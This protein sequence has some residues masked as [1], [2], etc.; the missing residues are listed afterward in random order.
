[1]ATRKERLEKFAKFDLANTLIEQANK[2]ALCDSN[3]MKTKNKGDLK[4]TYDNA[5][6]DLESAPLNLIS[7]RRNYFVYSFGQQYYDDFREKKIKATVDELGDKLTSN[8]VEF[9]KMINNNLNSYDVSSIYFKNM[10][11]I[12]ERYSSDIDKLK[13]KIRKQDNEYNLNARRVNYEDDEIT[14]MNFWVYAS[15][16]CYFVCLAIFIAMF[17]G[18]KLYRDKS[19]FVIFSLAIIFPFIIPFS[20][21]LFYKTSEY[22]DSNST[23]FNVYLNGSTM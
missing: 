14:R 10:I 15:I 19:N 13:S 4:T 17:L 5:Q 22:V 16:I 11:E 9:M 21:Q 7:A 1:M 23:N 6:K 20:L 12:Y 3:C 18:M 2:A 8:H